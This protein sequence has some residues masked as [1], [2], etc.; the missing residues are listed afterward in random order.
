MKVKSFGC[1]LIFGS[2]LSDVGLTINNFNENQ[3]G[4]RPSDLTWPSLIAKHLDLEYECHAW[5]GVGNFQI[6]NKILNESAAPESSLMIIG[7]TYID[8]FDYQD[9]I[10]TGQNNWKTLRPSS[11]DTLSQT[12][13]KNLHSQYRDKIL[14]LTYM[15]STIELLKK[16]NI[17]FI[18]VTQDA[19]VFETQWDYTPAVMQLQKTVQSHMTWFD[20][21]TFLLWSNSHGFDVSSNKHPLD[22]AHRAAADYIIDSCNIRNIIDPT[23]QA[24]S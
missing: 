18:M 6:Y 19:L 21:M 2:E 24:L 5:P 10:L 20:K 3:S 1:S 11:T 23:Q 16:R 8:R 14:T 13:Y 15:F 7:W 4:W 12:Y 17:P 9:Q 22:D